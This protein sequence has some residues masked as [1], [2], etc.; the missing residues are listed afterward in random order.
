MKNFLCLFLAATMLFC[1][2]SCLS[3]SSAENSKPSEQKGSKEYTVTVKYYEDV[4]REYTVKQGDSLKAEQ[5]AP[6]GKRIVGL[7]GVDNVQYADYTCKT[8]AWKSS[9]PTTLQAKYEEVSTKIID[10]SDDV[11]LDES[12]QKVSFYKEIKITRDYSVPSTK[13]QR[14]FV[15]ACQ[16][17][18][19]ADLTIT[20]TFLGKGNQ[21]NRDNDF[22]ATIIVADEVVTRMQEEKLA[23]NYTKYTMKAT[24]KAKQF[25]NGGY[26]LVV[27][28][29]SR[30]G[31]ENYT[32]KNFDVAYQFSF[33]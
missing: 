9:Y 12:P 5:L 18:P 26:K 4:S 31:Y 23:E 3:Y 8:D 20:V 2:T 21:P 1:M 19:Y 15:A 24:V 16:C 28:A 7:F 27:K 33:D 22:I 30:Y 29:T 10:F 14:D 32:V 6:S 25:T 17:N 11:V 13:E